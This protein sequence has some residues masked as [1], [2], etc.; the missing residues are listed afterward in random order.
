M[1]RNLDQI[2]AKMDQNRGLEEGMGSFWAAL[3]PLLGVTWLQ[4]A[5]G[6]L[7]GCFL[8]SS[9]AVLESSWAAPIFG[10][11]LGPLGGILEASWSDFD[12]KLEP[13]LCKNIINH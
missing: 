2:V 4:R 3:G 1:V 11:N 12:A 10:T 9:R 7:P 8:G 13:N 5:S 6:P